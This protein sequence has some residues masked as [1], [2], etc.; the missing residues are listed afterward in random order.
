M[1]KFGK[2]LELWSG[3]PP[4][5]H[6]LIISYYDLMFILTQGVDGPTTPLS[7]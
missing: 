7:R 6:L 4:G 2:L 1:A 5:L 3:S